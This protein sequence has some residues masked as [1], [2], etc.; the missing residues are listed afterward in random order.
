MMG[1]G[2]SLGYHGLTSL[3]AFMGAG[4][5][6]AAMAQA[7]APVP[8]PEVASPAAS[9][10]PAAATQEPGEII[11]T[12][13]KRSESVQRV[14]VAVTVVGQA[15]LKANNITNTESLGQVVPSL[16]FKRG[17]TNLNST[18]SIR[19]LGTQSFVSA[20]EPSVSAVVDGVVLGRSGM[21]FTE[22][23]NIERIEVLRGPQGTLFGKNA[24]AGAVSIITKA[25]TS[26]FQGDAS[27]AYY[28]GNERRANLD[29]SG[30]LGDKVGFAVSGV[31]ARYDG[32]A[33][34][35]RTG[36]HVNGYER[37]G[38]RGKLV[39][40]PTD[41]LSVT[42]IGDVVHAR[43]NC[44]ADVLGTYIPSAQLTNLF[45]PQLGFTPGPRNRTVNNDF[46]PGTRDSNA[47]VSGQIDLALGDYT[48]TSI[49]AFRRWSNRQ[50]RDGDFHSVFA[51]HV[52]A[53]DILQHD[54]GGLV[55]KQYSE[56]L[57]L[58]SPADRFLSFVVG[59]FLWHTR[60]DDVFTRSV[61][62]CTA[63]T[64][65]VDQTGFQPCA[66]G[67][68]TFLNTAGRANFVTKFGNQALFGQ[69][70]ANLTP[71]LRLLG[72]ARY[73]H[74]SLRYDFAR[75][76][77]P[78]TGPGIG[79]PFANSDRTTANGWSWKAGG[80]Y[81]LARDVMAYA[82]YSRGYKGPAFNVFFNMAAAN[83]PRIDPETSDAYEG[84]LKARLLDRRLTLNLA[85]F[86]EKFRNF[87][88]NS[89]VLV[90]GS[91]ATSLTN[92]GTVR[93][94]GF[95]IEGTFNPTPAF[96]LS[97]GYSYTRAK[98][99]S[100]FC[101][102]T[103]SAANLATCVAHNGQPLPFAPRDKFNVTANW[104]LPLGDDL[105]VKVNL[106]P[107]VNYQS[108]TNFDIDQTPLA[109]QPKYALLNATLTVAT[110]DDRYSLSLVAKNL[111]DKFYTA[112]ITPS[113]NGVAAGS[114]TRLQVPRDARRYIGVLGQVNF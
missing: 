59:G 65:P 14:P 78:A 80:Q 33:V 19:G 27:A 10:A 74:D 57:R 106:I 40:K 70:T 109:R 3:A 103:L 104:R 81:D 56:E 37:Y 30:P 86:Y 100:Y 58:A 76:V 105:P 48:L 23:T 101:P 93:S 113:G 87:Q 41:A 34:N 53:M 42:L 32:N 46:A 94:S 72:G 90:N 54:D 96:S 9:S 73:I 50:L 61:I 11:V 17:S 43:D 84:G 36:K 22:F 8:A 88:A 47:G 25:P 2:S 85:V 35:L 99:L 107:T 45:I 60:Q 12:A 82:T 20:S 79:A 67:A 39:L 102:A 64:L 24:S 92:A 1:R 6:A 98:I 38:F 112:F 68:S 51:T 95:E 111:A 108:R 5:P 4:L 13:Q 21:A 16:T 110:R 31:Y 69:A 71:S 49:S 7:Q 75:V 44:C 62:Q 28:E 66:A 97:G 55:F 63:S 52:A 83:T 15:L 29:L 91:V 26:V 18:L 77:L 114:Y 89:F